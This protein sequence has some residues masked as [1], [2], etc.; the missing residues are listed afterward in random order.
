MSHSWEVSNEKIPTMKN[1]VTNKK[2]QTSLPQPPKAGTKAI[3]ISGEQPIGL[4]DSSKFTIPNSS[5]KLL[6]CFKY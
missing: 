6:W 1:Y 3:L 2:I 5:C 4:K